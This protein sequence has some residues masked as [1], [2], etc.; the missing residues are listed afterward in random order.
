MN[1]IAVL[2]SGGDSPGMNACIRSV[3][4]YGISAGLKVYGVMRGYTGLIENDMTL[5]TERSV[6]N[7]IH[8]GGTILKTSRCKEFMTDEGVDTAAQ[9]LKSRGIDG[10]VVIGGDGSF[11]GARELAKRGILVACIPGTIDNNLFYTDYT[12]GF[13]TAVNTVVDLVN[14]V[15]DTSISH[16][17][18]SI[19]E[20][21]GAG[22]G[23]IA[24]TAGLAS[25]ADVILVPEVKWSVDDVCHK[26]ANA[27]KHNKQCS[28][29]VLSEH[30]CDPNDLAKMIQVKSGIE[31]RSVILGHVQRGGSPT[32][33]DRNLGSRCGAKAVEMLLQGEC[34]VVG[35]KNG[36]IIYVSIEDALH[37][38]R[39]FN[40]NDY[41]L[42]QKLSF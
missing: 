16:D 14:N 40:M 37:G 35:Y 5:M 23:D 1:T 24:L 41:I 7:I 4:R 20:V 3:V 9:N 29:I 38:N 34:G 10:L 39:K 11:R 12:L 15:R 18:V 32:A 21:M 30:V 6:G 26:L 17:R 42:A 27:R 13:D 19:V 8:V 2:T 28:I 25:G 36:K 33:F 22:C 31:C